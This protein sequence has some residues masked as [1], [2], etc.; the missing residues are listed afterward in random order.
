MAAIE[1]LSK[2][3]L[4]EGRSDPAGSAD[5][6]S[7]LDA[8]PVGV[9][10]FALSNTGKPCCRTVNEQLRHWISRPSETLVGLPFEGFPL[11]ESAPIIGEQLAGM[12]AG[13]KMPG[14]RINFSSA[15]AAGDRHFS[16]EV[17]PFTDVEGR[18]ALVC[19]RDRA[20]ELYAE[21]HLRATM[22]MDSLTGLPNRLALTERLDELM[23]AGE[24]RPAI[25]IVNIDRFN[26]I[27]ESLGATVGDEFLIA[28]A[29]RLS[30]CIRSNDC[31]ARLAADEFAI[32][33]GRL[34]PESDGADVIDRIHERLREPFALSGGEVY[35]TATIGLAVMNDRVADA[36]DL[37]HQADYALRTAKQEGGTVE[38]YLPR[39]HS[40]EIGLFHLEAEL[41]RAIER[42]ELMLAFQPLVNLETGRIEGAEALSRWFCEEQGVVLPADFIPMAE[43]TGLIVPLGRAALRHACERLAYWRRAIPAAH[44][45]QVAVNVSSV[46]FRRDDLVATVVEALALADLPGDAL[47]IELTESAIVSEPERVRQVFH[48]LKELGCTIAMDDFGTGYSSL[49]YLQSFPID[50]LKIDQSFVRGMLDSE[51][52]QNII[53]AILSLARS[54][55]MR[56]IA[57]GVETELQMRS[58]KA[59]G[60]HAGQ[61]FYFARPLFEEDFI[62]KLGELA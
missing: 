31:V 36:E 29:R 61:G 40:R 24:T 50:V 58:L 27:N 35:V 55:D 14:G 23:A 38:T 59:A 15:S 62:A 6:S 52:S 11:F 44:D 2:L 9:A 5:A 16:A 18:K 26:R 12:L 32:L 28:L 19:V 1:A 10:V 25:I 56:T 22:L 47:K 53:D 42:D 49:S 3:S 4:T 39:D 57:E 48:Q 17:R 45:L 34:G 13:K 46:Q 37:L 54:L 43:E 30:G 7:L 8:L 20:P 60:C 33:I 51:D 41:R 21:T